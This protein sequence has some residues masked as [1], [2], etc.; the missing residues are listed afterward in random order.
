MPNYTGSDGFLSIGLRRKRYRWLPAGW[1]G[2]ILPPTEG[3]MPLRTAVQ[4][5]A[6]HPAEKAIETKLLGITATARP[7]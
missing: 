3:K 5:A 4:M 7:V 2:G 1:S 6:L